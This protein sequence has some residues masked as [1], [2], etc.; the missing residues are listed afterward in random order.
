MR[1]ISMLFV[2]VVFLI[3]GCA[4][5]VSSIK[6]D[7]KSLQVELD[8]K[9]S[10]T[11]L[12][13]SGS[14]NILNESKSRE[15]NIIFDLPSKHSG[16]T[17]LHIA[18]HKKN[19]LKLNGT[20][21]SNF[22]NDIWNDYI[23]LFGEVERLKDEL[24]SEQRKLEEARELSASAQSWLGSHSNVYQNGQ[25]IEPDIGSPPSTA[26][27]PAEK[28]K[29]SVAMCAFLVGGCNVASDVI[30][31]KLG[32][33]IAEYLS[34]QACSAYVAHLQ[35]NEYEVKDMLQTFAVDLANN[36]ADSMMKSE[37]NIVKLFGI[38]AKLGVVTKKYE[39]FQNCT[40]QASFKC[41]GVYEDWKSQSV[42][43]VNRCNESIAKVSASSTEIDGFNQRIPEISSQLDS[44]KER[45]TDLERQ[46]GYIIFRV[47]KK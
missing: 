43:L 34:S 16:S 27:T 9:D 38:V 6:G 35:D 44:R 12:L 31:R 2:V 25:C 13:V 42:E 45:L 39:E 33:S 3:S 8:S 26:C 46:E 4:T 5:H 41:S 47:N 37:S 20:E 17:E 19:K 18:D 7:Y 28:D 15:G 36:F 21:R 24:S 11:Y 1:Y 14:N 40:E 32:S 23:E 30:G 22:G 10:S 29:K